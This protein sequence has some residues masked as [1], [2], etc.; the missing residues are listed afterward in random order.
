MTEIQSG[1]SFSVSSR[2]MQ[3]MHK[4]AS[5]NSIDAK[6]IAQL[7]KIA[8]EDAAGL[9][10]DEK[11]ILTSLFTKKLDTSGLNPEEKIL[12][13]KLRGSQ[14]S[15]EVV[16]QNVKTLKSIVN[17]ENDPNS[18]NFSK[19]NL[20]NESKDLLSKASFGLF[21]GTNKTTHGI[22]IYDGNLPRTENPTQTTNMT[23]RR[24]IDRNNLISTLG[25]LDQELKAGLA[26]D[27]DVRKRLGE[28]LGL[29][30]NSEEVSAKIKGLSDKITAFKR[31][32]AKA[33][34]TAS[35]DLTALMNSYAQ[36]PPTDNPRIN[37][38]YMSSLLGTFWNA[39]DATSLE[40]EQKVNQAEGNIQVPASLEE[41]NKSL[42]SVNNLAKTDTQAALEKANTLLAQLDKLKETNPALYEKV[43]RGK[44]ESA[45]NLLRDQVSTLQK[46]IQD[47]GAMGQAQM[48]QLNNIY[49]N[50]HQLQKTVDIELPNSDISTQIAEK[51]ALINDPATPEDQKATLRTEL[52]AL[53]VQASASALPAGS[54]EQLAALKTAMGDAKSAIANATSAAQDSAASRSNMINDLQQAETTLAN[55]LTQ[56][57]ISD[58]GRA[59]LQSQLDA[60][61]AALGQLK[62]NQEVKFEQPA[63][64]EAFNK[65]LAN[66]QKMKPAP[67]VTSP[68]GDAGVSPNV[69][70]TFDPAT[71]AI[72]APTAV[73][74]SFADFTTGLPPINGPV[75]YSPS[76]TDSAAWT[77]PDQTLSWN[78]FSGSSLWDNSSLLYTPSFNSGGYSCG[79]GNYNLNTPLLSLPSMNPS[80][81]KD[82][83]A[84]PRPS[85]SNVF[86][87]GVGVD[88]ANVK[89]L[90]PEQEQRQAKALETLAA[91]NANGSP[92]AKEAAKI[93]EKLVKNPN[94]GPIQLDNGQTLTPPPGS[95]DSSLAVLES[96][97][98]LTN[99]GIAPQDAEAVFVLAARLV[100]KG[101]SP[102]NIKTQV[103]QIASSGSKEQIT[104]ALQEFRVQHFVGDQQMVARIADRL[105]NSELAKSLA[106]SVLGADFVS[107]VQKLEG[108]ANVK[109]V[110]EAV[111]FLQ[112]TGKDTSPSY[113]VQVM[114]S[115]NFNT[116]YTQ[117]LNTAKTDLQ[118]LNSQ[119]TALINEINSKNM[120][121]TGQVKTIDEAIIALG[122]S[123]APGASEMLLKLQELKT[124]QT[125]L[126]PQ[127]AGIEQLKAVN[128][129][130]QTVKSELT[131]AISELEKLPQNDPRRAEV[132]MLKTVLTELETTGQLSPTSA[133]DFADFKF[134]RRMN[135][136]EAVLNAD[137]QQTQ[138]GGNKIR[139]IFGTLRTGTP[140]QKDAA[141]A[142][143]IQGFTQ[144][145]IRAPHNLAKQNELLSA[146]D[147]PTSETQLSFEALM[148]R[149]GRFQP[150]QV[151][152]SDID[153]SLTMAD[154]MDIARSQLTGKPPAA[155]IPTLAQRRRQESMT[156]LSDPERLTNPS[157]PT[158]VALSRYDEATEVVRNHNYS[159]PPEQR[160]AAW[161]NTL[162]DYQAS[163]AI[164]DRMNQ[165]IAKSLQGLTQ[166][167]DKYMVANGYPPLSSNDGIDSVSPGAKLSP[168]AQELVDKADAL[169]NAL[170]SPI[171]K[172]NGKEYLSDLLGKFLTIIRDLD[173]KTRQLVL[174]QLAQKMVNNAITQFY[175]DKLDE[176]NKHHQEA[177]QRLQV[178][179]KAQITQML[180]TSLANNSNSTQAVASMSGQVTGSALASAFDQV[181]AQSPINQMFEITDKMTPPLSNAQKQSILDQLALVMAAAGTPDIND[182]RVA[183]NNLNTDLSTQHFNR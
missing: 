178:N 125:Q 90:S 34:W 33:D 9:T 144:G 162:T 124:K 16:D 127:I 160:A 118:A 3:E 183:L 130:Y 153:A 37:S 53:E 66:L 73:D 108:G 81:S 139:R 61:R 97:Q 120:V 106:T 24:E 56:H 129:N 164:I 137:P 138:E 133:A 111:Q 148:E 64:Q 101:E 140:A 18:L 17:H 157:N 146:L 175:K 159:L 57:G 134:K 92:E 166:A 126:T 77:L 182:D 6:E 23:D 60:T 179:L 67:V 143:L 21:G 114:Q 149:L 68:P 82:T 151:I 45:V 100:Q 71:A 150:S 19:L 94:N 107:Q 80:P 72:L 172:G 76:F 89:P 13:D 26:P 28:S 2:F 91:I 86:L 11:N 122:R 44:D 95:F 27:S 109:T 121:K 112:K 131:K 135:T 49:A 180:E 62:N 7:V 30:P 4:A 22:T 145:T 177:L 165:N 43:L 70:T 98:E 75:P 87:E 14:T 181:D 83:A 69:V 132:A 39:W 119:A 102:E 1:N 79:L 117:V 105:D 171:P 163:D 32:P 147:L 115:P 63:Q 50:L 51:Q 12:F 155:E 154:A 5:D 99:K 88:P 74:T 128:T 123:S 55:L 54:Q 15:Q 142:E 156:Y 52:A 116:H 103:Q 173:F 78:A 25:P 42:E 170:L 31:D 167:N 40:N 41:I 136:A 96:Y 38:A 58:T 141:V 169:A 65:V 93:L 84:A 48:A 176:N 161:Q 168:K 152:S 110:E 158:A 29:D 47:G 85:M 59:Q 46:H 20:V 36:N 10:D 113:I 174:K 35:S 8:S 104:A